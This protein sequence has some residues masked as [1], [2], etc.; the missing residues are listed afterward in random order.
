M[1][2]TSRALDTDAAGRPV[3]QSADYPRVVTDHEAVSTLRAIQGYANLELVRVQLTV[4]DLDHPWSVRTAVAIAAQEGC[5]VRNQWVPTA[6]VRAGD[7]LAHKL[8]DTPWTYTPVT[9]WSDRLLAGCGAHGTD[10][11]HRTFTVTS[12]PWWVRAEW[13]DTV[14]DLAGESLIKLRA[15]YLEGRA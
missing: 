14:G 3:G 11:T 7:E 4:A 6:S 13:C 15:E 12:A 5:P 10:V 1:I 9:G 8:S 2:I